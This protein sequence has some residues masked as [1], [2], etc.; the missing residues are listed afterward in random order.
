MTTSSEAGRR[1]RA[2]DRRPRVVLFDVFETMLQVDALGARFVDV[3]RPAHEWELFFTRTLRDGMALTLAGAAPPFGEVA[4]AALRTTTGHTLSDEAL[5][6]VLAGF[7]HLPPHP[8]VEPALVAL[9]HARVPTYAFTHGSAKTACD[10]LDRAGL[11]TYLRGVHSAEAIG[12]FKPPARVYDWVCGQVDS[13]LDRTGL[14]AVHSWDVH[15]AVRAGLVGA[16]ATRL[17]GRVP[18]VVE[19]PHVSA[20]RVDT[21]VERLLALPA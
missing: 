7:A 16:L 13:P 9:A 10:A 14:V 11:R 18:A 19:P 3:G 5:D 8:D 21:A 4:R 12:S 2:A 15:G 6:H 17:E 1:P 20:T